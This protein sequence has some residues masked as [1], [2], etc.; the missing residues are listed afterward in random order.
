MRIAWLVIIAAL[1]MGL[2]GCIKVD[3]TLS[4]NKDGSGQ[5]A[6]KYGM[7]EQTIAQME[8]MKKMAEN[9][10]KPEGTEA[11][12]D[13]DAEDSPFDFDEA[14][15]RAKLE[16]LDPKGITVKSVTS[17][18]KDGWKYMNVSI[19][20]KDL[21]A[22]L[23]TDFYDNNT[24]SLTKNAEGN[25][26][27]LQ[28]S[29]DYNMG[30]PDK[31]AMD[32]EMEKQMLQQM[33]PLLK[34]M[35]VAMRVVLPTEVLDTNATE[36][37]GNEVSWIYDMDKDP[38]LLMKMDKTSMRVVFSGKD[39]NLPEIKPEPEDDDEE[40]V[41]VEEVEVEETVVEETAPEAPAQPAPAQ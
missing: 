27:L 14:K 33:A 30:G 7:S 11:E 5:L 35:S 2:V 3:Q 12:A 15:I 34:G 37:N 36:K 18:V 32:P 16:K 41:E 40:D 25:Y 28:Q 10:P 9:M 8:A 6:I 13:D 17:E 23:E 24:L 19:E 26:E 38:D 22:L 20:F 39:V 29:E 1:A 4:L 31:D 21:N